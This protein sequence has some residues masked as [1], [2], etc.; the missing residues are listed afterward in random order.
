MT[1]STV[2]APVGPSVHPTVRVDGVPRRWH[3]LCHNIISQLNGLGTFDLVQG[4]KV[5]SKTGL[6]LK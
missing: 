2:A 4:P 1:Y 5:M 6:D 3:A